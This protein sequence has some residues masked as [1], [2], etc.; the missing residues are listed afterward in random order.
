MEPI[1]N[2]DVFERLAVAMV[3]GALLGFERERADKPAG[4]RTYMLVCEGATLFMLCAIMLSAQ[5]RSFGGVSDPGRIASTVVQ[6]I[7]F[8]AGGVILT[9]GR[10]VRGLTTAAGLWVTA[11]LGLLIGSGYLLLA[12]VAAA[13]TLVA[14]VGL[15]KLEQRFPVGTASGVRDADASGKVAKSDE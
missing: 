5:M 2:L 3:V 14:L 6:G 7:G 15:A 1:T 9:T 13:L 10:Q 4:L 8:I 11:A 12:V